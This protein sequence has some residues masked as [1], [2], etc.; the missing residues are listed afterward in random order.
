MASNILKISLFESMKRY[1]TDI[2]E[3]LY[4][5]INRVAMQQSVYKVIKNYTLDK[6]LL[7]F[8]MYRSK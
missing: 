2:E 1:N 8:S 6:K 7:T 3:T 4:F 5:E